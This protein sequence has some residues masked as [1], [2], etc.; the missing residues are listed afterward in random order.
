MEPR[1]RQLYPEAPEPT[2]CD[3]YYAKGMHAEAAECFYTEHARLLTPKQVGDLRSAVARAGIEGLFR[4]RLSQLKAVTVDER[5]DVDIAAFHA[6][7]G[8]AEQAFDI[9]EHAYT[10]RGRGM[11]ALRADVRFDSAG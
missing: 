11:A 10:A 5:A 8:E 9:L 2:L 3:A 6:R 4:A 7:L 1:D